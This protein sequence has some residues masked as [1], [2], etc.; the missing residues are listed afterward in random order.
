MRYLGRLPIHKVG[1][2]FE[3]SSHY[4]YSADIIKTYEEI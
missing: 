4:V 3:K 2:M 1:D